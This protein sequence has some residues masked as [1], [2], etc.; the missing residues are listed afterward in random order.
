MLQVY[1]E[2][3]GFDGPCI[4]P[5]L[6]I[7]KYPDRLTL[8]LSGVEEEYDYVMII[9]QGPG[10]GAAVNESVMDSTS[11]PQLLRFLVIQVAAYFIAGPG[12]WRSGK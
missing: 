3:S 12:P 4:Y 2:S 9:S 5:G 7:I 1:S 6:H 10:H 11:R 8:G